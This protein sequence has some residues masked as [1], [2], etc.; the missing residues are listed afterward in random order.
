VRARH[1]VALG[2]ILGGIATQAAS[3]HSWHEVLSPAFVFGSFGI[4][5]G[6]LINLFSPEIGRDPR[7]TDRSYDRKD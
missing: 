3:V 7:S 2:L 6:T 5:G 4:I 1:L